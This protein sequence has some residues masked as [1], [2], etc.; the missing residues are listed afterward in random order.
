MGTFKQKTVVVGAGPVGSLAALYAAQRGD[1]VE[2]YELRGDLRDPT[3]IPL[4]FT[5]SINLALSE[6]GIH[7]MRQANVP[8]LLDTVL[9]GTIPMYG[10]MIH[11]QT[12]TGHLNSEAQL[13]DVHGR[14]IRAADRGGMN[15]T[16]LNYLERMPNV[17]F[18]FHHRLVGADFRQRRA[19]FERKGG[20]GEKWTTEVEVA[21]DF[22][23]GA[24]GAHSAVRY[25][26]MKFARMDYSQKYIDTLWCE[27]HIPPKVSA[28]DG[29]KDFQLSPNHLH[30][31]PGGSFMFIAIP[32]LDKSFTST[33]FLGADKFRE[34]DENPDEKLIPFFK[35]HFPGVVP[36]LITEDEAK[37]Q[38]KANPHLPLITL[39]CKPYHFESSVVI[40][41]DAAHAMVPF[42]GQ[43]M[44]A[45]LESVRVLY[46]HLDTHMQPLSGSS[47]SDAIA[48]ARAEALEAYT[49]F[50]QPDAWA[51]SDLAM[52]NYQE[53]SSDVMSRA[54]LLRKWIEEKLSAYVPQLGWATQYSRVSFGN[55]RY[56]DVEKLARR[57]KMFLSVFMSVVL[58]GTAGWA[59]WMAFKRR[60]MFSRDAVGGLLQRLGLQL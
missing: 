45:G 13:Y 32:S 47:D 31:W 1:E 28:E 40:V 8:G 20:P 25:H 11:G 56:S 27:F 30:I 10:R 48:A 44:N 52:R 36:D 49:A 2:I 18:F 26:L 5:K 43:G 58:G 35:Q 53:M 41:G 14:Y 38:Y 37:K 39:S 19:W 54:Y 21:F 51:I 17:K 60:E 6:R 12:M 16:L 34:L 24:D 29:K 22:M 33:L 9:S 42:Y 3:T 15:K 23:I 57:Q 4:N 7:S 46:D 59:G 50:R 55:Q